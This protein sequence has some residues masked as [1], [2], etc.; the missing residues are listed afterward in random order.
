MGSCTPRRTL[1]DSKKKTVTAAIVVAQC[2]IL[3]IGIFPTWIVHKIALA[4]VDASGVERVLV[5]AS[6][7]VV[8][9][10][11]VSIVG[12]AAV[13][14]V[15][16][17][18]AAEVGAVGVDLH[19]LASDDIVVAVVVMA[20][21]LRLQLHTRFWLNSGWTGLASEECQRPQK[22]RCCGH[23]HNCSGCWRQC[24]TGWFWRGSFFFIPRLGDGQTN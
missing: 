13:V 10:L 3:V 16:V 21:G 19:Y 5:V 22:Q 20:G 18:G 9:Q 23:S 12:F 17:G 1:I 6:A 4:D 7:V 2:T 24:G 11:V 14:G 8:I 15:G